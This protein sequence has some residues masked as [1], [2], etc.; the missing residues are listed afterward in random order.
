MFNNFCVNSSRKE[1]GSVVNKTVFS[2][3]TMKLFVNRSFSFI[4]C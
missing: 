4:I 3:D 1:A 2:S